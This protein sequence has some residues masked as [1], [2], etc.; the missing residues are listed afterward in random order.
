MGTKKAIFVVVLIIVAF[1]V[2][3]FASSVVR[4][5]ELDDITKQLA[6]L[7]R[8]LQD[9]EANQQALARQLSDIRARVS[10]VESEI[11]KREREIADEEK[12]L[13]H[14]K[15]RLDDRIVSYY[16]SISKNFVSIINFLVATNLDNS[17]RV[18]FYQQTVISEDRRNITN[19]VRRILA[20]DEKKKALVGE[21]QRLASANAEIDRQSKLIGS[22]INSKRQEVASLTTR[23]Q[24]IIASRVAS[25]NL[26]RSAGS[27]IECVDDR[28]LDPGFGSA[29]AFYTYGIP[30]RVG[31]NQYG[32]KGRADAGQT[33]EPI[34]RAYFN[35]D[36]LEKAD[37]NTKIR[38]DGHG[39]YSLEDYTKRIYE[40]PESWPIESL[41][42]QAI[43]ARSF[44][45]AYTNN[46]SGS[47]C[48]SQDC[49]VFQENE[50]TGAWKDAV[51]A[52]EGLVMKQGGS[53]IKAWFS[54]TD[55]GYTHTSAEV[56]G[57]STGW[58][59]NTSDTSSGVGSFSELNERAYDKESRCFYTAQGSRAEYGKSAWLKPSEVADIAN[60]LLLIKSKPDTG[61]H[62]YQV[63]KPNPDGTDNWDES[64][65]RQEVSNPFTSV[66]SISVSADFNGG[67]T[68]TITISGNRTE[69]FSGEEWKGRFNL[70]A[71]ANI[72]IVGPLYNVERR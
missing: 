25:L 48:D 34:L 27:A 11:P 24:Q 17:L 8:D 45:M 15:D 26:S 49:Q 40:V 28:K 66:S 50:K 46:G 44:A 63:D 64:R 42:A 51:N 53:I 65:V 39:E 31:L 67:R 23:Q 47:I 61:K 60:T 22:E 57:G 69:T 36:S 14:L 71:P 13:A 54:S 12:Q 16:K 33:Y 55:G 6:T 41:K 52:T 20:L 56:W 29:F 72:S 70:R 4:A 2:G 58:T 9:K 62:L 1:F 43:A 37:T 18:F 38:V 59:K 7:S 19:T 35:F 21:K 32:A 30:H 68:T 5:D 10:F 3:V